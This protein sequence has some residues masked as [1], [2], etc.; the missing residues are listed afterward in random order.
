MAKLTKTS[1]GKKSA[2]KTPGSATEDKEPKGRRIGLVTAALILIVIL[3]IVG[4]GYYWFYVKPFQTNVIIVGDDTINIGYFIKRTRMDATA[5]G[6]PNIMLDKLNHEILLKQGAPRYGI[7]ATEE[8][9]DEALREIARGE[10]ETISDSEFKEWYRQQRNETELSDAEYRDFIRTY[11]LRIRLHGYLAERV[12]T[13]VE[14]VH[15]HIIVLDS[16]EDALEV[17]EKLEAGADFADL[18]REVSVDPESGENGGDIGWAPVDILEGP[19]GWAVP[20]LAIGEISPP[21]RISETEMV[22][23]LIMVSE[24]AAAREVDENSLLIM[25]VKVLEDWLVEEMRYKKIEFHGFKNGFDSETYAWI[26]WQL[27]KRER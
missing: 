13:V 20:S 19:F 10:S 25:K 9:I 21:L 8:D 5:S 11:L 3:V 12:P 14:Q 15:L 26:K 27:A 1:S 4:I 16:Y 24:K 22:F 18:A 2:G 17:K 23:S 6:D 7:E